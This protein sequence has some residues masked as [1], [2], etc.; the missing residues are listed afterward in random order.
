MAPA[1]THAAYV[2]DDVAGL[3][4]LVPQVLYVYIHGPV[5][6]G[7]LVS[8]EVI[9]DPVPGEDLAGIPGQEVEDLEL[10]RVRV[11]CSPL[12]C[13]SK[14]SGSMVTASPMASTAESAC[15]V[16]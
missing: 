9:E 4:Q 11:T 3:S 6:H 7:L 8:P 14:R 16:F 2:L 13:T 12:T 5:Q 15:A 1:C 10:D